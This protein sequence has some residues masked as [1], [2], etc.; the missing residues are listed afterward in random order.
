VEWDESRAPSRAPAAEVGI[1]RLDVVVA[2]L[3][4]TTAGPRTPLTAWSPP[5]TFRSTY[6]RAFLLTNLV[7]LLGTGRLLERTTTL[8]SPLFLSAFPTVEPARAGG[9]GEHTDQIL[10][11][12]SDCRARR[13]PHP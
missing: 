8:G 2:D 3:P 6:G 5:H 9:L 10:R 1:E 12:E 13:S 7:I 11:D 4:T